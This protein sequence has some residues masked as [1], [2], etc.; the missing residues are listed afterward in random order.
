MQ[1]ETRKRK[2][3]EQATP[4]QMKLKRLQTDMLVLTLKIPRGEIGGKEY[5]ERAQAILDKMKPLI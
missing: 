5:V 1:Y 4:Q 2:Q 3:R